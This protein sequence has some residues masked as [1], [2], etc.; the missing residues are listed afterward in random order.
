MMKHP[1]RENLEIYSEGEDSQ[2][3]CSRCSFIL[4]RA[5]EDWRQA[6]K[7]KLWPPSKAGPLMSDL[8]DQYLL[9]QLYCPLCGALFDTR[10]VE[11]A[12]NKD[13]KA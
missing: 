7:R 4:S 2:I 1:L 3:R 5:N 13:L 6:S 9:E 8:A 11:A 10:V 12:L